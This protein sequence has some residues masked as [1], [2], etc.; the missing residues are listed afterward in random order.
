LILSSGR[1]KLDPVHIDDITDAYLVA[2]RRLLAGKTRG[3][4]IYALSSGRPRTL[5][6][7]VEL[8]ARVAGRNIPASWGARP[9]RFREVMK[10]WSKGKPL[11]GWRPRISLKE[12]IILADGPRRR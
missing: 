7:I 11:P 3:H 12:G 2:A 5:R 4:E 8:Y 10:P 9:Y 1:Q 6:E